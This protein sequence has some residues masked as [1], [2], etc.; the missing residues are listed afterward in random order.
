M[1]SSPGWIAAGTA[2][3]ALILNIAFVLW[4]GGQNS[5]SHAVDLG[6]MESR[7]AQTV[8]ETGRE[9]ENRQ[10]QATKNI[11]EAISGIRQQM[12]I[13]EKKTLGE[14]HGL[15]DQIRKVEIWV[16]DEFVR[17]ETFREI[18]ADMKNIVTE[19]GRTMNIGVQSVRDA[20]ISMATGAGN[21][22]RHKDGR[23]HEE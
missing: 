6:K 18:I 21:G 15:S 8:A 10:D 1:E 22:S 5:A 3:A 4:R 12:E 9:L 13:N 17:K 19:Q 20:I 2:A 16:R 14:M 11:G 23:S 7:L